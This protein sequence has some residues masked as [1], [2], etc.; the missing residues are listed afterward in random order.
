VCND[1]VLREMGVVAVQPAPDQSRLLVSV[2]PTQAG[3][4]D[5]KLVLTHLQTAQGKLR[6]EVAT[7][8]HRKK[9]PELTYSVVASAE[10]TA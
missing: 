7:A 5:A 3:P 6:A 2:G 4:F 10:D 1:D 9:V 8:I